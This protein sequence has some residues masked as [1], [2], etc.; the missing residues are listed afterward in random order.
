VQPGVAGQQVV[1]VV[2]AALFMSWPSSSAS[3]PSTS[4]RSSRTK[5]RPFASSFHRSDQLP[6]RFSPSL[7]LRQAIPVLYIENGTVWA[8]RSSYQGSAKFG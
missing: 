7:S 4:S 2:A 5:V 8:D 1:V 3:I 6:V